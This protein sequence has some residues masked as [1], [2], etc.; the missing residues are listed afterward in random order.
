MSTQ[1]P[2]ASVSVDLDALEHYTGIYGLAADGA[3]D[4]VHR[5][6]LPRFVD[7]FSELGI[8]ATFFVVGQDLRLPAAVEQLGRAAAMGFELGNH[9]HRHRYE[10]S[11][12]PPPVLAEEILLCER[13]LE[14]TLGQRPRGFRAPGYTLSPALLHQ[15]ESQ[16]Y[17]YDSSALPSAPYYFAKAAALLALGLRGRRSA[18][19]LGSPAV[20]GAPAGPY[21][22]APRRPY[23]SSGSAA[24]LVELPVSTVPGIGLPLIGQTLLLLGARAVRWLEPLLGRSGHL[25]IELHGVDALGLEEDALPRALA[26][27][28]DLRIPLDRKLA[29]LRAALAGLAQRFEFRRL[30]EV[31]QQVPPPLAARRS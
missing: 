2:L 16:G 23:R 9:S 22:L 27:Q 13:A 20:L 17:L 25:N 19:I 5:C 31:A 26:V 4:Q 3:A 10:L 30:D 29:T 15:L 12:L 28:P 21:R 24:G 7:L 14:Q 1:R 8:P 11:R 6:A 18:S